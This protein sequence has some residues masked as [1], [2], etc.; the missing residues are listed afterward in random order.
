MVSYILATFALIAWFIFQKNNAGKLARNVFF[1]AMIAYLASWWF[2]PAS[3]IYKVQILARDFGLLSIIGGLFNFF[4]HNRLIAVAAIA[5]LAVVGGTYYLEI[6]DNT[7]KTKKEAV[8]QTETVETITNTTLSNL[9]Q[10]GEYLVEIRE[11]HEINEIQSVLDKYSITYQKAFSEIESEDFTD[12]DD[13]YLLDV[14]QSE[15]ANLSIIKSELQK[16]RA[17][18]WLEDNEIIV[19]DDQVGEVVTTKNPLSPND[20][21]VQN[22]WGFEKEQLA[23]LHH[24]MSQKK[25]KSKKRAKIA[26]LD[27]GVD[28]KHEDIKDNFIST[29]SKYDTD[30]QAHG[31][32]C[33]GIAAAVTG[34]K[35]GIASVVHDNKFVQVTSVKVLNDFGRGT[36][37]TII[38]G[39]IEAADKG[40][41]VISMSLGGMSSDSRQRAYKKA[42]DYARKKGAI[43]IC[44]AGNS[45]MNAK[46]YVPAGVEGVICVSAVDVDLNRASFSN[47][48]PDV[49][50]G[51]AAPGVNIF[52]TIPNNKYASFNGTSMACPHVAGLV[53]LLRSL[54]P[55]MTTEEAYDILRDTGIETNDTNYTGKFIQPVKAISTMIN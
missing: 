30:K 44:A 7:F 51:I 10:E 49:R 12:L 34:N 37:Q 45:N 47:F 55:D 4:R 52:S 20:P 38:N 8:E 23:E 13:F 16:F 53:G 6:L 2:A 54:N 36:Q 19:L 33:A 46:D 17:V 22:Q 24:I 41:D 40:A 18:E 14:P 50:M 5:A 15:L 32:H 35:I 31:T 25:V 21:Y 43:V 3:M 27:T 39:M 42:V 48:V 1:L 28:S 26:I 11:T 9:A 29:R